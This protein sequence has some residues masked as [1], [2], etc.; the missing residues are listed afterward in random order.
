MKNNS[1]LKNKKT[2]MDFYP[3][4]ADCFDLNVNIQNRKFIT[5]GIYEFT[6]LF[7]YLFKIL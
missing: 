2:E 7:I 3:Y 5:P 1:K 4:G 6:C